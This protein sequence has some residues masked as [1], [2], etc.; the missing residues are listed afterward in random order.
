MGLQIFPFHCPIKFLNLYSGTSA[1]NYLKL[2]SC[3]RQS[4]SNT[5]GFENFAVDVTS[6]RCC[7]QLGIKKETRMTSSYHSVAFCDC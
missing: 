1:L 7:P 4:H 2:P 3:V 6:T 5:V